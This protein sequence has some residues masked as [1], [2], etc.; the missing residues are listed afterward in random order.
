LEGGRKWCDVVGVGGIINKRA[1]GYMRL[2]DVV[3]VVGLGLWASGVVAGEPAG[4]VAPVR[5]NGVNSV[6]AS[7]ADAQKSRTAGVFERRL[8]HVKKQIADRQVGT[9]K[10]SQMLA[11][12]KHEDLRPL[13]EKQVE[14]GRKQLALLQELQAALEKQ[15]QVQVDKVFLQL[16]EVSTTWGAFGEVEARLEA[17]RARARRLMGDNPG[18]DVK[19]A[20][21]AYN[22]ASEDML[23]ALRKK[24]ALEK[25]MRDLD[26]KQRE[27]MQKLRL[28]VQSAVKKDKA[29]AK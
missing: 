21:E 10:L 17:D 27:A 1:G 15:D 16:Q 24:Q 26:A 23:A 12:K 8:E 5:S 14:F 29:G 22:T 11:D 4:G 6:S 28:E 7:V 3:G 20:W 19:A 9:D 2:R 25:E 13:L 18:A